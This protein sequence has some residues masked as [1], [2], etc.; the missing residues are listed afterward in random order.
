[1]KLLPAV[2][3]LENRAVLIVGGGAVAARKASSFV[4]CSARVTVVCPELSENFPA[5]H[6]IARKYENGDLNGFDL[7]CAA[8]NFPEINAQIGAE[9]KK[10]GIWCNLADDPQNSDF[11]TAATVRRGEIAVGITTG[12][13]SPVLSRH[14]KAQIEASLGEEYT[15]LLEIAGSY[16]IEVKNRGAFWRHLLESEALELLKARKREEAT[17]LVERFS[18]KFA[19]TSE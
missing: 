3:N 14:V 12:G 7:V 11:H 9:A 13:A 10:L 4:E 6:H 15:Q 19:A 18:D 5:V 16:D 17:R 1:M 2:L 8:T